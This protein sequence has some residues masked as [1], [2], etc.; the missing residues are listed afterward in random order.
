MKMP[1]FVLTLAWALTLAGTVSAQA[2]RSTPGAY[3]I[4]YVGTYTDPPSTS[5]GIYA[6]RFDPSEATLMPLGLQARSNNLFDM[7]AAPNGKVLYGANWRFKDDA[8]YDDTVSAFGID[9][10]TGA[11]RLIDMVDS[12]GLPT[13]DA[14]LRGGINQVVLDPSGR[15]AVACNAVGTVVAF[16]VE[17]DGHL[18]K[19]IFVERHSNDGAVSHGVGHAVLGSM[20]HGAIFSPDSKSLY[21][22]DL[23]LDR[24]YIYRVDAA[25][26][27]IQPFST[28]FI[29]VEKG[30]GPRHFQMH[31]NGKFLYVNFEQAV[32]VKA[33][34]IEEGK[35]IE[36]QSFST[37]PADWTGIRSS[38]EIQIDQTGRYL[39]VGN[40]GMKSSIAAYRVDQTTGLLALI[41]YTPV[42]G[43][44]SNI[45]IDPT[46][47]FLFLSNEG[48]DTIVGLSIDPAT[49]RLSPSGAVAK[50]DSPT[51]VRFV[52]AT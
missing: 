10:Q 17:A 37:L 34:R 14:H 7:W 42:D 38:S 13:R 2:T 8:S 29:T 26:R 4:M 28:P 44:P 1:P 12:K 50:L 45:T 31:P 16:P 32:G 46:N 5:K 15:I 11:L 39:Y 3:F 25:K 51:A 47:H 52:P 33:F 21:V 22:A 19:A 18:G 9:S 23:G 24:I 20:I 48:S 40:R 43:V 49:G 41:G 30:S 36:I 35:P 6:W 27:S